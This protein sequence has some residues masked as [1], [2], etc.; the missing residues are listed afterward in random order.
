MDFGDFD[1]FK[2]S[3]LP[4]KVSKEM[5]CLLISCALKH[6]ETVKADVRKACFFH[7]SVDKHVM[8][9]KSQVDVFRHG[10]GPPRSSAFW[11]LHS[12]RKRPALGIQQNFLKLLLIQGAKDFLRAHVTGLVP[13]DCRERLVPAKSRPNTMHYMK[14]NQILGKGQ[15]SC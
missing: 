13:S 11:R 5:L 3:F 2:V 14:D 9:G 15:N 10:I 8:D 6:F 12:A 4:D 1:V 7:C